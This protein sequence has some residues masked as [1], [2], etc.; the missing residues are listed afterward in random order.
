MNYHYH[1]I[2]LAGKSQIYW[3]EYD[4]NGKLVRISMVVSTKTAQETGRI[5]ADQ[6]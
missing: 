2:P 6:N 4:T 5:L 3:D 1:T